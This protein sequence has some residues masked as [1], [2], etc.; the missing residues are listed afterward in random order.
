MVYLKFPLPLPRLACLLPYLQ[1]SSS[2]E[3]N[4]LLHIQKEKTSN[5]PD[6]GDDSTGRDFSDLLA[7]P[8][9]SAPRKNSLDV[10][11]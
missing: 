8:V 10:L 1:K 11:G 7:M 2:L 4:V 6:F 9:E 5:T 3:T